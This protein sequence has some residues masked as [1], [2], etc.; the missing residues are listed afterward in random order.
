MVAI[1]QIF[2]FGKGHHFFALNQLPT[3]VVK[4]YGG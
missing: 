1:N 4:I 3:N 2:P